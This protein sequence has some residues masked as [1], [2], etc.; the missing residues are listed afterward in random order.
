MGNYRLVQGHLTNRGT[1]FVSLPAVNRSLDSVV[2]IATSYGL[3]D[4]GVGVRVPGRVKNFLFSVS[5]RP[6]L[7]STQ[8]PIQWVPGALSLGGKADEA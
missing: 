2:G 3:D 7:W 8:P 1:Q 5:F 6:A 4:R